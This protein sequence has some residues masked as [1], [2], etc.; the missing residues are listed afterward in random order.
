MPFIT[1]LAV[2]AAAYAARYRERDLR[3]AARLAR[4]EAALA[5]GLTASVVGA[6][7]NDSGPIL[8]VFGVF[9]LAC[10]TAYVRAAAR[11]ADRVV[12]SARI[13]FRLSGVR[14]P[15]MRIALVSPYSWT[16]PGGVTRH[17]EA[18]A[19]QYLAAGH[20]VRV[21][22]P[23][24]P[25]D[26]FAARL[27][28]GRAPGAPARCPTASSRSAAR[29]ASR[30]TARSRTS[31]TAPTHGQRAAPRAAR[32]RLRRR[33][34]ARAGRAGARLGRA[35]DARRAARR[36]VSLLLGER[37]SPTTSRTC[38]GARR[39]LNRLHVRDRG[40]RGRRLDR[41]ALLRRQLPDHPQRRRRAGRRRPPARRARRGDAAADRLHRP[42]R[43]AQGP[44]GAA[45]RLRGAARARARRAARRR[46]RPATR[47]RR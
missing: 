15:R 47:S 33:A 45:A 6:L 30:P 23:V 16:Y 40:L 11:S 9:I 31:P 7:F 28:R 4:V 39:R 36:H 8:L 3:A 21:L 17:I 2:L 43:R 19:E 35:D 18:L 25:D 44:A 12:S 29:S 27:H 1:V 37:R 13:G 41:P 20:D 42:G 22:A 26:R 34:P 38:I 5:G 24:D 32:R 46:R 14:M 10:V